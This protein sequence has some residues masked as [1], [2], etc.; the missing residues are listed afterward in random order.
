MAAIV[1]SATSSFVAS[2]SRPAGVKVSAT[3]RTAT[4]MSLRKTAAPAPSTS[5]ASKTATRASP[6]EG[7]ALGFVLLRVESLVQEEQK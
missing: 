5:P 7:L 2:G 4:R 3:S 6:M 1:R